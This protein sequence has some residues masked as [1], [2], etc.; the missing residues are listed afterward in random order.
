MIGNIIN[1]AQRV[2]F[3]LLI[4]A[5]SALAQDFEVSVEPTTGSSDDTF[6][7]SVSLSAENAKNYGTLNFENSEQ[8]TLSSQGQASRIQILNGFQTSELIYQ[9]GFTC[10]ENL[11][12]GTYK[13]PGA[14]FSNQPD[15]IVIGPRIEIRKA[16]TVPVDIA[17]TTDTLTPYVGQQLD[18]KIEIAAATKIVDANLEDLKFKDFW[19][20]SYGD[21]RQTKRDINN[22]T[23]VFTIKEA[24][25]PLRTGK[26][27]IPERKLT[28]GVYEI[29]PGRK[30]RSWTIFDE[31]APGLSM[32]ND[33]RQKNITRLAKA[34][35]LTVR[36]L[37]KPPFDYTSHI[38]VGNTFADSKIDRTS[39]ELGD[40]LTLSIIIQSDGNLRPLELPQPTSKDLDSFTI[41]QDTTDIK[42]YLK[43]DRIF[44]EKKFSVAI[45]PKESGTLNLPVY[46]FLFFD[47]IQGSYTQFATQ[48]LV[49]A[50][51]QGTGT[52]NNLI[53][54]QN[55]DGAQIKE[56]DDKKKAVNIITEDIIS[57][58]KG[59]TVLEPQAKFSSNALIA[60]AS[61]MP[62]SILI[63]WLIFLKKDTDL[64]YS[65]YKTALSDTELE[66]SQANTFLSLLN[67]YRKYLSNRLL[68]NVKSS[69]PN[70]LFGHVLELT[71]DR[72]LA[73]S[74][75]E[76]L[77][78][79]EQ[80]QYAGEASASEDQLLKI[81]NEMRSLIK[82]INTKTTN[83][84]K[85]KSFLFILLLCCGLFSEKA[86]ADDAGTDLKAAV[87]SANQSYEE[88]NYLRAVTSYKEILGSGF[89]TAHLHYNTANTYLRLKQIGQAIYHYRLALKDLPRDPDI[90][91][92]LNYARK[93]TKD[94][95]EEPAAG[96][97]ALIDQ[98]LFLRKNLSQ[99]EAE[100]LW[101][102]L[103]SAFWITFA[104]YLCKKNSSSKTATFAL[105]PLA[106][107]WTA[108][109]FL[110]TQDRLGK[111]TFAIGKKLLPAVITSREVEVYS[112][113][114][115]NYQ[116]IFVLHDGAEVTLGEKR[117]NWYKL[118]LPDGKKG[119]VKEE[120]VGVL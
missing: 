47:P 12:P 90:L 82:Q 55:K 93:Q 97:T 60:F 89:S 56:A 2:A 91:A 87:D 115:E 20:E 18:Y 1:S 79:F 11:T 65:S 117:G 114:S 23:S 30:S 39:V 108:C 63:L 83:Y 104:F 77:S 31:L 84:R 73:T 68:R 71:S 36:P 96:I 19:Q 119:W 7:L 37:P 16:Q 8:F 85:L 9:F 49:L 53:V 113:D 32:R 29:A 112:G 59:S 3:L 88:G 69:T 5:F 67:L 98:A 51:G 103:Y 100:K 10:K 75:K 6:S 40:S 92:N 28:A 4:F 35:K 99:Y 66:L 33:Y 57:I 70:E 64:Q 22:N 61:L 15:K 120:G 95:I 27:A 102:I 45:V 48:N 86:I 25:F 42:T 109:T 50:V 41:Y 43:N 105:L 58:H 24:L 81:K 94:K 107:W 76:L 116:A 101:L 38:P 72:T 54:S 118:S 110:T 111:P 52:N 62:L 13:L 14:K 46:K 26:I 78:K 80:S 44:F 34:L 106:I 17:Q 74:A 21:Q